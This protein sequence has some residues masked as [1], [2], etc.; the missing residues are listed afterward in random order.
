MPPLQTNILKDL[1]LDALP[2]VDQ[3]ELSA[4]MGEVVFTAVMRR[5]WDALDFHQQDA[6]ASLFTE[7]NADPESAEKKMAIATFLDTQVPDFSRYV[8]EELESLRTNH[9]QFLTEAGGSS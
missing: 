3:D 4:E 7:S 9:Q 1:G 6:L 8:K 5:V 2:K